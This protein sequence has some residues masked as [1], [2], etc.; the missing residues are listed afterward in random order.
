MGLLVWE[1]MGRSIDQMEILLVTF[2]LT[3]DASSTE[4]SDI[5]R[6]IGSES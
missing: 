3:V 1:A 5:G 4:G 6:T 2:E